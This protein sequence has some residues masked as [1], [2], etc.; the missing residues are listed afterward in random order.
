VRQFADARRDIG[1]AVKLREDR[2]ILP[3]RQ[4]RRH[5]DIGAFEIHP[6]QH[7]VAFLRH[8]RAQHGDAAGGWRDQPHDHGDGGGLAGAVAAEQPGDGAGR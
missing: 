4:P 2:Q 1:D 8:L 5:V 6:V 3:H 7:A